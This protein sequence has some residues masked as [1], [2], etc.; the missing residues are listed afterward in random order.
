MDKFMIEVL[1]PIIQESTVHSSN[2]LDAITAQFKIDWATGRV[3]IQSDEAIVNAFLNNKGPDAE[4]LA[5]SFLALLYDGFA[6]HKAGVSVEEP[7]FFTIPWRA[8]ST[9]GRGIQH[10]PEDW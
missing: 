2:L 10:C 4:Q 3:A 1:A 6:V 9:F 8:S 7:S 5:Q